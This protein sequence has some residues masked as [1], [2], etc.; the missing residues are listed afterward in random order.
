[1]RDDRG[2]Y[3][4]TEDEGTVRNVYILDDIMK[5]VYKTFPYRR[6]PTDVSKSLT[7]ET[8][9]KTPKAVMKG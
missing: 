9:D 6:V 8:E 7:G 1:M 4:A 3:F 5:K 2:T